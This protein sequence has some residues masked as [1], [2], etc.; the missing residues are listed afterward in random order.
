MAITIRKAKKGFVV[1]KEGL[2]LTVKGT[3]VD[4]QKYAFQLKNKK[5]KKLF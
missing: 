3:K 2:P 4:A 1:S 5:V